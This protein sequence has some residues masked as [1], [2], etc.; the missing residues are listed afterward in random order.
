MAIGDVGKREWGS[1]SR[2]TRGMRQ[3]NTTRL[4]GELKMTTDASNLP[5]LLCPL[6]DYNLVVQILN[7]SDRCSECGFLIPEFACDPRE[8]LEE[9]WNAMAK[10]T[11]IRLRKGLTGPYRQWKLQNPRKSRR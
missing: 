4:N 2:H 3:G 8:T 5:E 1:A 10:A 6:C 11:R 7:C 9:R